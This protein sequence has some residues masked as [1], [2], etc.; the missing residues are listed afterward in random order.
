[1]LLDRWTESLALC[2]RAVA[3]AREVGARQVEGHALN[4][5]GLDLAVVGRLRRTPRAARRGA[6]RIAR[7]VANADD[8]G[9]GYVEPRRGAALLRRPP[10]RARGRAGGASPRPTRSGINAD[11]RR[12]H[13]LER[14]RVHLR[15][16]RVGRGRAGWRRRASPRAARA[17]RSGATGW[18]AGCRCWSPAVTSAPA[19]C[20]T[21]SAVLHRGLSGRDAVPHARTASPSPRP[22]CGAASRLRP[23]RRSAQGLRETEQTRVAALPAALVPG[24]HARRGGPRRGRPGAPRRR[25]RAGGDRGRARICGLRSQPISARPSG[26]GGMA[27]DAVEIRGRARDRSRPNGRD[28]PHRAGC[29]GCGRTPPRAGARGRT[30]TSSPT[31]G[32]AR[33]RRCSARATGPA[34]ATALVD[35]HRDRDATS[36]R[37]PLAASDGGARRAV[38]HRPDGATA[39]AATAAR[40]RRPRTIPSA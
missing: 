28:S 13:P 1:M 32:G 19:R 7:E 23:W 11:V 30:R 4:T 20:S 33:P 21:S 15:A 29:R 24:G 17:R 31:A 39:P 2:E 38:P 3:M 14:R 16:R 8:I 18:R 36:G 22:P 12:L 26:S 10:G 5:L 35:A 6:S 25:R 9:R 40:D 37:V 34:A 27:R